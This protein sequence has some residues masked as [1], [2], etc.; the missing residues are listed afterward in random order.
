MAADMCPIPSDCGTTQ[1][2]GSDTKTYD[3]IC[4]FQKAKCANPS[5]TKVKDSTC[6]PC[7]I[8]DCTPLEM[9]KKVC[10]ST[11]M[12]FDDICIYTT[13]KCFTPIQ[14]GELA[15]C[16]AETCDSISCQEDGQEC[17]VGDKHL[18]TCAFYKARCL[19]PTIKRSDCRKVSSTSSVTETSTATTA[20]T[21][22]SSSTTATVYTTETT[23]TVYTTE[24][25]S[26]TL[27]SIPII[28]SGTTLGNVGGLFAT[29]V[30]SALGWILA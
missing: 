8:I 18:S 11:G 9:G 22:A 28:S 26:S 16:K 30:V 1:V 25:A 29:I 19:D 12:I 14:V 5:L 3:N 4:E 13:K 7:P 2:C 23:A 20:T 17:L 10:S 6:E 21:A 24:T 15:P 27:T